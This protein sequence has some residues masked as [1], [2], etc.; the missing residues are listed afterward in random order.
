[1]KTAFTKPIAIIAL[2]TLLG[3]GAVFATLMNGP[4][5]SAQSVIPLGP[6]VRHIDPGLWGLLYQYA[7][8]QDKPADQRTSPDNVDVEI[9]VDTRI[10]VAKSLSDQVT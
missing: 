6:A 3:A 10:T 9:H 7:A 5:A 4:W 2:I 8:E 1:M